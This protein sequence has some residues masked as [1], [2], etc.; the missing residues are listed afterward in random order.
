M[1]DLALLAR[2]GSPA[3]LSDY[4]G[5][6]T[7]L[8]VIHNMGRRCPYCTLW[9]DGFVGFWPHLQDRTAFVLVSEDEPK[10]LDEF[11]RS[12]GWPFP[13]A[14]MHGTDFAQTLGVGTE[15]GHTNPGAS[16]FRRSGPTARF[17][18]LASRTSARAT[19]SAPCGPSSTSSREVRGRGNP[20]SRTSG[21]GSCCCGSAPCEPSESR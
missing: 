12:R 18:G 13:V 1:P 8:L 21:G 4:F 19:A 3:R 7:D 16:G 5:G 9:A 10:V 6:K 14:S 17:G 2:N 15:P 20:S 11:A